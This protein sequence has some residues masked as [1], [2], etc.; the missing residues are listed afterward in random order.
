V[1]K[2]VEDFTTPMAATASWGRRRRLILTTRHPILAAQILV[3]R[4]E[5][6]ICDDIAA[7]GNVLLE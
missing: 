3:E 6:R 2:V 1:T 5:D 7:A 4:P